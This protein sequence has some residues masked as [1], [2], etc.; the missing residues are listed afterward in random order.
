M[1]ITLGRPVQAIAAC[2]KLDALA[3]FDALPTA[4]G[5]VTIICDADGHIVELR[6]PSGYT[7]KYARSTYAT[8]VTEI[9]PNGAIDSFVIPA[10]RQAPADI[11]QLFD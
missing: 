11:T 8:I 2:D 4:L 9:A 7:Y 6:N 10:T 3:T 1:T 5:T